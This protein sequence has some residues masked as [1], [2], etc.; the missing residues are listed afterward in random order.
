MDR[1]QRKT[2]EAIYRAFTSLMREEDYAKV[3]VQQII[4]RADIGRT[5]FYSHFETK[6]A[7]LKSFCSDIFDHVFSE[8]PGKEKTHDFSHVH[9]TK[10]RA[11]HIL[12]HLQEHIGVLSGILS[13]ESDAVF[14]GFFKEKLAEL[15]SSSVPMEP[16]VP[17]EYRLNSIVCGFCETVRWWTKHSGYTPEEISGFFFAAMP[18]FD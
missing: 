6:D 1:R 11:T 14:M 13:G 10:A 17:Y 5:T 4:D 15:F 8:D 3:T 16:G 18:Y 9:D 12:Y 2:R 7:L